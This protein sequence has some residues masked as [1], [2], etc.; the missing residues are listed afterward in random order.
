MTEAIDAARGELRDVLRAARAVLATARAHTPS[1]EEL[2]ALQRQA[3]SG[4][5]GPGYV[6][7][8]AACA[9]AAPRGSPSSTAAP[10]TV[11]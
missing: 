1:A 4:E 8:R 11:T 9:R 5:L 7:G 10:P 3:L 2:T 6:A